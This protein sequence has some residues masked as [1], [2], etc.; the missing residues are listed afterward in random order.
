MSE[1]DFSLAQEHLSQFRRS[2]RSCMNQTETAPASVQNSLLLAFLEEI[3]D[4]YSPLAGKCDN[5]TDILN[6]ETE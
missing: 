5:L 3:W 2:L 1:I 6:T 4:L